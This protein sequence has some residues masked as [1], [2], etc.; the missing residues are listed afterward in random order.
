MIASHLKQINQQTVSREIEFSGV[1]LHK[2]LHA[3]IK[4]LPS[5]PDTGI[6][7]IRTD[8]KENNIIK[9]L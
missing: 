7:F 2:G 1:G 3:D 8:I 4:I 9:A 5:D 6:T